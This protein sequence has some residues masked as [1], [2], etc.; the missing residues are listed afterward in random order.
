MCQ[1]QQCLPI[2]QQLQSIKTA[3]LQLQSNTTS[4]CSAFCD[5]HNDPLLNSHKQ[6]HPYPNGLTDSASFLA[7]NSVAIPAPFMRT[8][9]STDL[10]ESDF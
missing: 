2:Q 1:Q 6:T 10:C 8:L 4:Y 5:S 7:A 9:L 3:I